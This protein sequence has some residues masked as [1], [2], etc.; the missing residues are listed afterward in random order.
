[1]DIDVPDSNSPLDVSYTCN[2]LQS[3]FLN[4]RDAN[5]ITPSISTLDNPDDLPES[6]SL[7]AA[8]SYLPPFE[9]IF[10]DDQ[11]SNVD[12]ADPIMINDETVLM[13]PTATIENKQNN[14]SNT[15][16]ESEEGK[17]AP[18]ID[19]T[20]KIQ[21]LFVD[22]VD[23]PK[24]K[25]N[26]NECDN[27][28]IGKDKWLQLIAAVVCGRVN[29]NKCLGSLEHFDYKVS[30]ELVHLIYR[31]TVCRQKMLFTNLNSQKI[32]TGNRGVG[33]ES[34]NL[35]TV[36]AYILKGRSWE[37]YMDLKSLGKQKPMS[38]NVWE[39]AE[40]AI[41]N[42]IS[43]IYKEYITQTIDEY[44]KQGEK[45]DLV[46]C[47]D[48][49]WAKRI[50]SY[51]GVYTMFDAQTGKLIYQHTMS[52]ERT[53]E[54]E[55][56]SSQAVSANREKISVNIGES[57]YEGTSKGMEGCGFREC[58]TFL[59][60]KK[61]LQGVKRY[62]CDQD[63]SVISELK[64]PRTSHIINYHDIG[65]AKKNLKNDLIKILGK[66][67]ELV[68]FPGKIAKWF[69]SSMMASRAICESLPVPLEEKLAALKKEFNRRMGFW[70]SHYTSENCESG[71]PCGESKVK[72]WINIAKPAHV[73]KSKKTGTSKTKKSNAERIKEVKEAIGKVTMNIE[74]FAHFWSTCLVESCNALRAK[75]IDKDKGVFKYYREKTELSAL[76]WN[77][78]REEVFK[79]IYTSFNLQ[80]TPALDKFIQQRTH[81]KKMDKIRRSSLIF[82]KRDK[83]INAN[84]TKKA[85]KEKEVSKKTRDSYKSK[86]QKSTIT[87]LDMLGQPPIANA[88]S[89]NTV[90]QNPPIA[91][92]PPSNLIEG[93]SRKRKTPEKTED[94][95]TLI[96]GDVDG[97]AGKRLSAAM[98]FWGLRET[99]NGSKKVSEQKERLKQVL[100]DT[101]PTEKYPEYY[102]NSKRTK[103]G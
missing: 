54:I 98:K 78:G 74:K 82:K 45:L 86:N 24:F 43:S 90:C 103:S 26:F 97:L 60:G 2:P 35:T 70:E 13:S 94:F 6:L 85:V 73:T 56:K 76:L 14:E 7:L 81:K 88:Q 40:K 80:L 65:H 55:D 66:S 23:N 25:S 57:N 28:I 68:S 79:R 93:Q 62:V 21:T 17:T 44:K 51:S 22:F 69:L 102:T 71:C 47:G 100:S 46:L 101:N 38:R 53:R 29:N 1:M 83:V 58:I 12:E 34:A 5:C 4:S 50:N 61:I 64:K 31:C 15:T 99:I 63:S 87:P 52:K 48:G 84:K 9:M 30:G 37:D 92:S 67:Q 72:K 3:S 8:A 33:I 27:I 49:A 91:P 89:N 96:V 59:E 36:L 39:A 16:W 32:K 75:L 18:M 19:C 11:E 20:T 77:E 41:F 95:T 10:V 42:R